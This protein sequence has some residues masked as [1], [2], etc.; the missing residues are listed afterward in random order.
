MTNETA[1]VDE[2]EGL[3]ESVRGFLG[4]HSDSAAVRRLMETEDGFD[5]SVWLELANQLGMQGMVIPEP[6]GGAGF[7]TVEQGVGIE[8]MGRA[9]FSSPYLSSSVAA[10][11]AILHSG[12]ESAKEDFLPA[13]SSGETRATLAVAERTWKQGLEHPAAQAVAVGERWLITGLKSLVV[14]GSSSD[15]LIVTAATPNG[16][17]MFTVD[18]DGPG[19][20]RSALPVVDMTRRL[21]SVVLTAA[22]ARMIGAEGNAGKVLDRA[23]NLTIAALAAEQVGAADGCLEMV[24][25]YLKIREQF[26]RL[27]GSFQALKHRCADLLVEI[28]TAR[29]LAQAALSAGAREDWGQLATL[30]ALAKVRSWD[31]LAKASAENVQLHGGIGFT[32][33]IDAHLYFKRAQGNQFLFGDPTTYRERAA[34]DI[35]L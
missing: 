13:L 9:L 29:A 25:G 7:S 3:R 8:E 15:V 23:M 32:W 17:S 14:D 16:T 12:D 24:V 21:S 18:A 33:A 30:A 4:R 34:A 6:Y 2:L 11:N 27:L 1:T 19:V 20:E 28:E 5:E 10:T 22:P 35:G 26:G 31:V